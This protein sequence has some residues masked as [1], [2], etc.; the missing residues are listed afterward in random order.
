MQALSTN[1]L[2]NASRLQRDVFDTPGPPERV[3][4]NPFAYGCD[5]IMWRELQGEFQQ[6]QSDGADDEDILLQLGLAGQ[7]SG[8]SGIV[9]LSADQLVE[10]EAL[11]ATLEQTF[12]F[13]TVAWVLADCLLRASRANERV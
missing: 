2:P 1:R 3:F 11:M 7:G 8:S 4:F 12:E 9:Y 6:R 5:P 13:A 10:V